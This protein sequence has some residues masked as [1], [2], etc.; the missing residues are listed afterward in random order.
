ME[1]LIRGSVLPAGV[2][3]CSAGVRRGEFPLLQLRDGAK[4]VTSEWQAMA[5]QIHQLYIHQSEG[6]EPMIFDLAKGIGPRSLI[7]LRNFDLVSLPE[8]G[9]LLMSDAEWQSLKISTAC[10]PMEAGIGADRYLEGSCPSLPASSVSTA[11]LTRPCGQF[12][13]ISL[14][15]VE[16]VPDPISFLKALSGHLNEGGRILLAVPDLRQNPSDLV[17]AD[18]CT[19]F[20]EQS[21]S[22]VARPAGLAVELLSADLLPKELVAVLSRRTEADALQPNSGDPAVRDTGWKE[23]CLFYFKLLTRCARRREELPARSGPS[24]S[25][26]VDRRPLTRPELN[27]GLIFCR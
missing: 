8:E 6:A 24:A 26:A 7:L 5:E 12:D 18:H 3:G 14:S 20:V 23:R 25:W 1:M 27:E 16:H 15:H 21:L 2:V 17:V 4:K 13:V 11:V 9:R 10:A 19:H 22:Y